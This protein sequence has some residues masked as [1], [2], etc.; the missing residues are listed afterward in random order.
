MGIT[1]IYT[2][3][4][5]WAF[6]KARSAS[7][8]MQFTLLK[9]PDRC[10]CPIM[11]CKAPSIYIDTNIQRVCHECNGFEKLKGVSQ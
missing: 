11:A 9:M 1:I 10:S 6:Q 3:K 8:G 4:E 5:R 7:E 2:Y